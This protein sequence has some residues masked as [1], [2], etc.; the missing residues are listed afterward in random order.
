[1]MRFVFLLFWILFLVSCGGF[2]TTSNGG[3]SIVPQQC[4]L[5]PGQ[6]ISLSVE[7]IVPPNARI[8]WQATEGTIVQAP[9]GYTATYTAPAKVGV[10]RITVLFEEGGKVLSSAWLDC[11]VGSSLTAQPPE[12]TPTSMPVVP[13]TVFT[14][15]ATPTAEPVRPSP[16]PTPLFTPTPAPITLAITEF[17]GNPCGGDD[18][19]IY[20]QYIEL[21]NYGRQPVNV[22]GLWLYTGITQRIIAWD[23]HDPKLPALDAQ[24]VT[25]STII[26]P[27]G[28][29]LILSPRYTYAHPPYNMPYDIPPRTVILTVDGNRLGATKVGIVAYGQGRDVIVLY[30]GGRTILEEAIA[31]YGT[32]LLNTFIGEIRD[33]YRDALPFDLPECR[34]ANLKD[35]TKGDL[36]SNWELI[37]GGTPGEGPYRPLP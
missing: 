7:G 12:N 34:S 30:R 36:Q 27:G 10:Y 1:M 37:R 11:Q 32:P 3:P 5:A 15:T 26:P 18:V 6:S 9:A 8:T 35:L 17:M 14:F 31:T 33:D 20:N 22:D 29:A 21:Y 16:T 24:L 19:T 28:F 25:S 2:P 13:T 4:K 23:A